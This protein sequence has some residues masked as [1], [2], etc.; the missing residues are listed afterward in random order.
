MLVTLTIG[1]DLRLDLDGLY[2]GDLDSLLVVDPGSGALQR[3]RVRLELHL[4]VLRLRHLRVGRNEILDTWTKHNNPFMFSGRQRH[5]EK[6]VFLVVFVCYSVC[7]QGVGDPPGPIQWPLLYKTLAL[8]PV[9]PQPPPPH[10]ALGRPPPPPIFKR[11]R[12]RPH[13]TLTWHPP[14]STGHVEIKLVHYEAWTVGML[15]VGLR[16]KCFLV[17]SLFIQDK[18]ILTDFNAFEDFN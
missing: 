6:V 13:C 7:S 5:C 18:W 11:I 12:L 9:D 10:L 16:L 17:T 2:V 1:R 3:A 4:G 14:H 8:P 15:A